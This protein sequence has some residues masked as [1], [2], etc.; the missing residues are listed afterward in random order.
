MDDIMK[1]SSVNEN[2][3]Q[4]KFR[5]VTKE[6]FLACWDLGGKENC[7][8]KTEDIHEGFYRH[9]TKGPSRII[10]IFTYEITSRKRGGGGYKN[11]DNLV[12]F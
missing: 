5:T 1:I 8:H 9:L 6:T 2:S 3:V 11:V 7:C 12:T 10:Y 4:Q